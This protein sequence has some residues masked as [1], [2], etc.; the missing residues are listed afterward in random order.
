VVFYLKV[1]VYDGCHD[2]W[3]DGCDKEHIPVTMHLPSPS[4]LPQE[5]A[6]EEHIPVTPVTAPPSPPISPPH[7]PLPYNDPRLQVEEPRLV[8]AL[9]LWV[10]GT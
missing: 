8:T 9:A 6:C 10:S 3:R 7:P 2:Q 5:T 1:V 4:A